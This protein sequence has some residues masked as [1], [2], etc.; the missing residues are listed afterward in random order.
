MAGDTDE[1]NVSQLKAADPLTRLF[2]DTEWADAA[3]AELVSIGLVS[4]S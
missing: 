1:R 3:G 4:E 2:L